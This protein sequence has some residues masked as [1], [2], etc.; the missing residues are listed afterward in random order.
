[1]QIPVHPVLPADELDLAALG[2]VLVLA[3][4]VN[5][6]RPGV[7]RRIAHGGVY[8][9]IIIRTV[10][11]SDGSGII[12]NRVIISLEGSRGHGV[13]PSVERR[14]H[15]RHAQVPAVQ[16]EQHIT[17]TRAGENTAA[18]IREGRAELHPHLIRVFGI[19]NGNRPYLPHLAE[20]AGRLVVIPRPRHLRD[21]GARRR[22]CG[23]E[24]AQELRLRVGREHPGISDLQRHGKH[25]ESPA[26]A[27]RHLG[28]QFP[29]IDVNP[30]HG[31]SPVVAGIAAPPPGSPLQEATRETRRIRHLPA[32]TDRRRISRAERLRRALSGGLLRQVLHQT[33]PVRRDQVHIPPLRCPGGLPV[34][35]GCD[36]AGR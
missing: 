7:L 36:R 28:P 13:G 30:A 12:D 33:L 19:I 21:E 9:L 17:L 15:D 20:I 25:P 3:E 6:A 34:A 14:E 5:R 10:T 27:P 1:M 4:V 16:A 31:D 26:A 23:R 29:A 11:D 24:L 32:A 22:R 35:Q 18:R 2:S 8:A